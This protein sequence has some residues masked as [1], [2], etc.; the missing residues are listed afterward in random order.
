MKMFL[1][2]I[3]SKCAIGFCCLLLSPILV[4]GSSRA[5]QKP[6]STP[7]GFVYGDPLADAPSLAPRGPFGV[8]VRT[9]ALFNPNQIDI[10]HSTASSTAPRYNRPVTLEIWYPAQ[11][12]AGKAQL[13]TYTDCLSPRVGQP[14][15]PVY[16]FE[17]RALRDALPDTSKG[18]YPLI[19]VSH[20]Y[21]GSRVMMSYLTE[22]LASKGYVVA[23]IDHADS[24]HFNK[25]P[26]PSTLLN[27][28]S[29]ITFTLDQI[30]NAGE[31]T[32]KSSPLAFLSGLTDASRTTLIGYSMG[33]FGVLNVAGAGYTPKVQSFVGGLLSSRLEGAPGFAPDPRV[34]AVVA[35]APWGE[36]EGVWDSDG[37]AG[38]KVP[39]LFV[40]GDHDDVASYT[41]GV[42]V[43]FN[44]AVNSDRYLLVYEN[45]RHNIAPNPPPQLPGM[46]AQAFLG[47]GEPAWDSRRINNV[48]QH[49][50]T[51]FLDKYIQ[52][53]DESAYLN[54]PSK[55]GEDDWNGF[56]P[57]TAV[58]LELWHLAPGQSLPPTENGT[59]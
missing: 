18:P 1:N 31:R 27:R 34:K 11:I 56:A 58:G 51:A 28:W 24:T 26:F 9:V 2:R 47:Y 3:S 15:P 53:E 7:E 14:P 4:A 23:A 37:L 29:D 42:R 25:G 6:P 21:P 50:V 32:A 40:D 57:R 55:P 35:F 20:G 36:A 5:D 43:I 33:G 52:G 12:P 10:V 46:D 13:T 22:N 49:F 30:Q 45:A 54:L 19:V 59:K 8:G 17:G 48:N 38:L 16:S 39:I 41:S 44:S